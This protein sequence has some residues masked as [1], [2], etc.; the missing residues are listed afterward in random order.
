MNAW[1]VA[2]AY[3]LME[4][5]EIAALLTRDATSNVNTTSL[6]AKFRLTPSRK[7]GCNMGAVIGAA[8]PNDGSDS[9]PYVY[10]ILS[11][12][13]DAGS[14]HLN[15][16]AHRPPD[17]PTLNTWGLAWEREVGA[18]TAHVEYFGQEQASPT[19]QLGL[20]TELFKNVQIDGTLGCSS[21]DALFSMGLKFQF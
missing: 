11:C 18:M 4:G 21:G 12:N 14:L 6:Q 20:R 17:G 5:V 15:L 10:G 2:P 13:M 7:D 19:F 1:T 9:T 8:Q 16:G 3:G